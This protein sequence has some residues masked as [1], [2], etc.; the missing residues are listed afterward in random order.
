MLSRDTD[1]VVREEAARCF[2]PLSRLA[3][4][5]ERKALIE[6][7]LGESDWRRMHGGLL[8]VMHVLT[9]RPL[10]EVIRH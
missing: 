7:L 5:A 3:P 8:A 2:G 9:V 6:A 1:D 4:E 10:V